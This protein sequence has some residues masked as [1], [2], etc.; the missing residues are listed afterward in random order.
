MMDVYEHHM[1]DA[2]RPRGCA[3]EL[4]P[5]TEES[6]SQSTDMTYLSESQQ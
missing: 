2:E 3:S 4:Q 1:E 6:P 5:K